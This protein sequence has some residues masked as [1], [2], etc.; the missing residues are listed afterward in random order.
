MNVEGIHLFGSHNETIEFFFDLA[1][2][3]WFCDGEVDLLG[4][5]TV[6]ELTMLL[7]KRVRGTTVMGGVG[8]NSER[9][10]WKSC[11]LERRSK[12]IG[13]QVEEG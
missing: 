2:D 6:H 4:D 3:Y 12:R 8:S 9:V 13:L 10:V 11:W 1:M 7:V 5:D